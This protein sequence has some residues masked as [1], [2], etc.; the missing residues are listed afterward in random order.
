MVT[1]IQ[2]FVS[3]LDGTL[4]SEEKTVIPRD[5][6][7]LEKL[8]E[9][10]INICLAS[11]RNELEI[12]KSIGGVY[13]TYHRISQNGAQIYTSDGQLLQSKLFEGD[14]AYQLYKTVES[15]QLP[16]HVIVDSV[17]EDNNGKHLKRFIPSEQ[18]SFFPIDDTTIFEESPNLLQRIGK[19]VFPTKF[20]YFAE[21]SHL[22]ELEV[23]LQQ[24]YLSK[25]DSFVSDTNC[26]DF[27]PLH[28]N[29]GSALR[30]LIEHLEI[31]ADEVVCIGD[32][33]NDLSMFAEIPN[34]FAM[35]TARDKVRSKA[36]YTV[37]SVAEAVNWTLEFNHNEWFSRVI[38]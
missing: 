36:K 6:L 31:E 8:L 29:K 18:S 15:Y 32:S 37:T 16:I 10:G 7:A 13:R 34:S 21:M 28:V 5:K 9:N 17:V 1:I 2:L 3:D 12:A 27:M 4:L 19:D 25:F 24:T 20:S 35:K 30:T 11:G 26:L 38:G 14:F 33:F 22:K 23:R